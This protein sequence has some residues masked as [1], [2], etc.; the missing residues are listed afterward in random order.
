M[1][2]EEIVR[3]AGGLIA[4]GAAV[5]VIVI[6]SGSEDDPTTQKTLGTAVAVAFFT[7]LVAAGLAFSRRRP[8]LGVFAYL[9]VAVALAGFAVVV[10]SIWSEDFFGGEWRPAAYALVVALAGGQVSVLLGVAEPSDGNGLRMLRAVTIAALVIFVVLVISEISSSGGETDVKGMAVAALVYGA[11]TIVL[12]LTALLGRGTDPLHVAATRP[13]LDHVGVPVA[14]WDH[15]GPFYRNVLGAEARPA[16]ADLCFAWEGSAASAIEH[17]H[18]HGVPIL[19]PP[20]PRDGAHG[21][22]LSIY[23]RD[24]AGRLIE[25]IA[26]G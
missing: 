19:G 12:L 14:D 8:E 5:L 1:K 13:Q 4:V 9:G 21:R 23:F 16:H 25:L 18:R 11:G 26:Y 7:P 15:S 2:R 17:L 20:A 22:G 10:V 24:P 3:V 6:L